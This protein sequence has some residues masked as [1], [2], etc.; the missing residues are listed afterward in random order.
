MLVLAVLDY[1]AVT[2]VVGVHRKEPAGAISAG[3]TGQPGEAVLALAGLAQDLVTEVED[4]VLV[5]LGAAP[6]SR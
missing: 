3:V 4:V 1:E 6:S 5:A 2:L